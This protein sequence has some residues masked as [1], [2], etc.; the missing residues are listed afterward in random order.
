MTSSVGIFE[1]KKGV[2]GDP[3]VPS[4]K[5]G[6]GQP[7]CYL[8][9]TANLDDNLE[10][11]FYSPTSCTPKYIVLACQCSRKIVPSTCMGLDCK[12]CSDYVGKRRAN[13]VLRR[14]LGHEYF[15]GHGNRRKTVIYTIFT[16]PECIRQRYYFDEK[17]WQKVRRKAW[18]ILKKRFGA[19]Y[20]V[21]AT[22]PVGDLDASHFHPH[23][24]FLWVQ[25]KGWRPFLDV[26]VLRLEWAKVLGVSTVDV[27]SQYSGHIG[28]IIHWANYV[29]RTFPGTHQWTGPMR[30]YGKYPRIK[31]LHQEV[32]PD[33]GCSYH[34][35]GWIDA[36]LV[37]EY[38]ETGILMG[39]DPPWERDECIAKVKSKTKIKASSGAAPW[40]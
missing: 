19:L 7:Q 29:T 8:E 33:C 3:S 11:P 2:G 18:S 10:V 22:H 35:I 27:H 14:L 20:G 36:R 40:M 9:Y 30:W 39:R 24:N 4:S 37:D 38:Y 12:S 16:V 21:E 23:L 15:H 6:P 1:S 17:E 31:E 32:C 13:S 5:V 34:V 25:R 28:R 26:D